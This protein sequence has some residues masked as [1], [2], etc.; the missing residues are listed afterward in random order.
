VDFFAAPETR[1]KTGAFDPAPPPADLSQIDLLIADTNGIYRGKRVRAESLPAILRDGIRMPASIFALDINGENVAGTGLVWALGDADFPVRPVDGRVMPMPWAAQPSGQML[2]TMCEESGEGHFADPRQVLARV[3]DRFAVLG[4][5]P[6]VAVELEFYLFAPLGRSGAA[7]RFPLVPGAGRREMTNQVYGME[8]LASFDAV[9][10]AIVEA[11]AAQAIPADAMVTEY[12]P[13]QYEINL[14]HVADPAVAADHGLLLKRTVKEVARAHGLNA[15]F[16]AKPLAE[17]AGNGLHLHV[18][19]IDDEGRNRFDGGAAIV[20]DSLRHAIG[21][22]CRTMAESMAIFAPNANSYRRFQLRSYAPLAPSWGINNRTVALRVPG[23][24]GAARRIEH[25]V[26]GA[27]ANIYLALAAV[28]A[29]IHWG[30][31]N[32]ADPGEPVTGNAYDKIAP[33][34]PRRWAEALESFDRATILP[35]YLG[36]PYCRVFSANRRA[37]LARFESQVCD[38]DYAWYLPVF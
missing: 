33:S 19:L 28:L 6:V 12:G 21:G 15:S 2:M 36:Q 14:T 10:S 16:M 22:L 17:Q 27:D 37:E 11:C 38:V 5:R 29:G 3:I 9:L 30:I 1:L 18:S 7:P 26:A 25:R 31:V 13:S 4:L 23:G 35:D 24:S 32:K 34:L 20:S 8:S